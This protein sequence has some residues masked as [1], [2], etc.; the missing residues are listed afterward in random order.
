MP[1]KKVVGLLFFFFLLI[2]GTV[3]KKS[4]LWLRAALRKM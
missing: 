3:G 2:Y 1:G 4:P